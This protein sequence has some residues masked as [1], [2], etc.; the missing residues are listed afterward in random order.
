LVLAGGFVASQLHGPLARAHP[1]VRVAEQVAREERGLTGETILESDT[2]RERGG[3]PEDL[4]AE[5]HALR[6]RFRRG[7]W[8]WGGFLGLVVGC[9]LLS[10]AV[11]R[12]QVDWEADR[13]TCLSCA[14][15]FEYCPRE[16]LRHRSSEDDVS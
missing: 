8:F 16:R 14:R 9:K 6:L 7:G 12:T 3:R 1:T 11:R 15:C 13:T 2:F 10:L 5:A 4:Y